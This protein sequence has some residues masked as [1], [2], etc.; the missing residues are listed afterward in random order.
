MCNLNR[1]KKSA[2]E[3]QAN[4]IVQRYFSLTLTCLLIWLL[5]GLS[6]MLRSSHS[7]ENVTMLLL[8]LAINFKVLWCK[9][10][11]K[12]TVHNCRFEHLYC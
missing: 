3:Y 7:K 1:N 10:L 12:W 2:Y 8:R 5:C 9:L 11:H 6:L 4:L